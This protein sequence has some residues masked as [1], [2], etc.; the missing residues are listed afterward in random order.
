MFQFMGR[1]WLLRVVRKLLLLELVIYYDPI[2]SLLF[3]LFPKGLYLSS[4]FDPFIRLSRERS[5]IEM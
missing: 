1:T 3:V 5:P 2:V 4:N